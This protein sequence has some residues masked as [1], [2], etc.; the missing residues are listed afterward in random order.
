M[1]TKLSLRLSA[2]LRG[3]T[4][5]AAIIG[6][7]LFAGAASAFTPSSSTAGLPDGSS[8]AY[9]LRWDLT[10]YAS[11]IPYVI[12]TDN[13]GD[14]TKDIPAA[15]EF[16]ILHSAF[17]LWQ[18]VPGSRVKF[19]SVGS[20]AQIKIG[21]AD[22]VCSVG[23][24]EDPILCRA[25][26]LALNFQVVSSDPANPATLGRISESDIL[27]IDGPDVRWLSQGTNHYPT[28]P[29]VATQ[30]NLLE[31]AAREVGSFLGLGVSFVREGYEK[32]LQLVEN[33]VVLLDERG[34]KFRDVS[35]MYPFP[36]QDSPVRR[37]GL[38]AADDVAAL[39][40]KY[41][42]ADR[43]GVGA[44]SGK[45]TYRDST[46]DTAVPLAGAHVIAVEA[47]SFLPKVGAVSSWDGSYSVRGLAPGNYH[48][49]V[50]PAPTADL[51]ELLPGLEPSKM[52]FWP[53][54][55]DN[56]YLGQ[57]ESAAV[58][59]VT[60][61]QTVS[62]IDVELIKV[63]QD[64][65]TK[66]AHPSQRDSEG[67]RI[68]IKV[69]PDDNF[70][71]ATFLTDDNEDREI[72]VS[73][74]IQPAGDTDFYSIQADRDDIYEVEV[75]ARRTGSPLNPRINVYG[76][77]EAAIPFVTATNTPNYEGDARLI[78][79]AP[80]SA[81][82]FIEV[83]D[84]NGG[85]GA[86]HFYTLVIR[87][88]SRRIPITPLQGPT[89]VLGIPISDAD[90]HE[91][92]LTDPNIFG[93]VQITRLR[94]QFWDVDGD[95]GLDPDG[96][97]FLPPTREVGAGETAL[98]SG[99][100]LFNDDGTSVGIFD[101]DRTSV[102][103]AIQDN[104]LRMA[105]APTIQP[106]S[107]GFEVTFVPESPITIPAQFVQDEIPDVWVVV[108]PSLKLH[109]GDDFQVFIP[110]NGI[111]LRVN[112]SAGPQTI[113]LPAANDPPFFERDIFTGE[114]LKP[115]SF[116][117]LVGGQIDAQ[118]SDYPL[119]GLNLLGD[120]EEQYWISKIEVIFVGYS[121]H[122]MIQF[123][124]A[125][126]HPVTFVNPEFFRYPDPNRR[127]TWEMTDLLPLTNGEDQPGGV[128]VYL[129]NDTLGSAGDGVPN[130]GLDGDFL[131]ALDGT[132]HYEIVD[133]ATIPE[134]ILE[135]LIPRGLKD[136]I[137]FEDFIANKEDLGLFA[138]KAVLPLRP[139]P[140]LRFPSS[141]RTEDNT[142]GPDLFVSIRTS[143]TAE[144]LDVFFP[145]IEIGGIEVKNDLDT[146]LLRGPE[147]ASL[148]DGLTNQ[149][150][151]PRTN[152]NTTIIEVRPQPAIQLKDLISPGD[153][154]NR[155]NTIGTFVEGSAPLAAVGID[156]QDFGA[157]ALTT[158]N[159]D[160]F[161][162][163]SFQGDN[164]PDSI[165]EDILNTGVVL[166]S[167]RLIL[168]PVE[169]V[170]QIPVEYLINASRVT[171]QEDLDGL[172]DAVTVQDPDLIGFASRGIE[173]L[174]D[175][176]TPEGNFI[177]D[178]A[179]GLVDEE[180]F[181]GEDDDIDGITDES[182]Q[183][184]E[185]G[186]GLNGQLDPSDDVIAFFQP[187]DHLLLGFGFGQG[188][189]AAYETQ[190]TMLELPSGSLQ[191]DY[192]SLT[193][194]SS[195]TKFDFDLFLDPWSVFVDAVFVRVDH[196]VI[197]FDATTRPVTVDAG[198]VAD[199]IPNGFWVDYG[200]DLAALFEET[201]IDYSYFYKTQVPNTNAHP[202]F[203]NA[204]FF[205]ALR[206]GPSATSGD[207]FRVRIPADG[208]TYSTYRSTDLRA[209]DLRPGSFP[210][211]DFNTHQIR[212]GTTNVPP[213]LVFNSP[214]TTSEARAVLV[215]EP[216]VPGGPD[217]ERVEYEFEVRFTFN[218]PDN[219][220]AVD[221]YYDTNNFGV[222]GQ[223]IP[224]VDGQVTTNILD[225]DGDNQL[226]FLFRFPGE[227]LT[228]PNVEVFIYGIV[229][230]GINSPRAVYSNGSIRLPEEERE[231]FQ[232]EEFYLFD[233]LGQVFGTGGVNANI[234]D[235]RQPF[236]DIRD[237]ELMPNDRGA[238][239]LKA[240]GQVVLKG[241]A[242]PWRNF[243]RTSNVVDFGRGS[244]NF[245]M[246]LARD[247][248]PDF[249]RNGMYILDAY[250]GVTALGADSNVFPPASLNL[251]EGRRF[252][253]DMARDMELTPSGEGLLI[254]DG[255][256]ATHAIGDAPRVGS[257][258]YF[259]FDIARDLAM[260]PS[261][262]GYYLLDGYGAIFSLGDAVPIGDEPGQISR[263]NVPY[264][265]NGSDVYRA[266]EISPGN[267][268][269]LVM[270]RAGQVFPASDVLL[271]PQV[272]PPGVIPPPPGFRP[273]DRID[274][275]QRGP[276]ANV[277]VSELSGA[278]ID[279]ETVGFGFQFRG[280][281]VLQKFETA[282]CLQDLEQI[283]RLYAD[284]FLDDQGHNKAEVLELWKSF[285]DYYKV[286]GCRIPSGSLTVSEDPAVQNGL[287]LSGSMEI[288][289]L[290]PSV[291][292]VGPA[293]EPEELEDPG[294]D[295]EGA[296][297]LFTLGPI[298]FDQAVKFW[299]IAD[300]RGWKMNI[301]DDDH[302]EGQIDS[303]D[304]LLA[305]RDFFKR[306]RDRS[307]EG[308]GVVFLRK[309]VTGNSRNSEYIVQFIEEV[310]API[311]FPSG[312][313]EG[314]WLQPVV[315]FQM[316]LEDE[317]DT[318]P[319]SVFR[320][321]LNLKVTIT[322]STTL[323]GIITGG[324]TASFGMI[325]ARS[326]DELGDTAIGQI[327]SI[328]QVVQSPSGWRFFDPVGNVVDPGISNDFPS[329]LW[330]QEDVMSVPDPLSSAFIVDLIQAATDTADLSLQNF[331]QT[332][333]LVNNTLEVPPAIV[334]NLL[335]FY[336]FQKEVEEVA[337]G[338]VYLVTFRADENFGF[339]D[340]LYYATFQVIS[341]FPIEGDETPT[342]N[343][344]P[345]R[346][347]VIR[348]RFD[349]DTD[350][351]PYKPF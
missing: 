27:F 212:V 136:F 31:T 1:K 64:G 61:N 3:L 235:F 291:H 262:N 181:N 270:D 91:A 175:D 37:G 139:S 299:E 176:D 68:V 190:P 197:A 20:T 100:A 234:P 78:F 54:F 254:L 210:P 295:D 328:D 263:Q 211:S 19:Q 123:A 152:P 332:E 201:F 71:E 330:L 7:A 157:G 230:D 164:I 351:V 101:Y 144:S 94:I 158:I 345:N 220:A 196:P 82:Y 265:F 282:I 72:R 333:L 268:G 163:G 298:P 304:R 138:F 285:F 297:E 22:S 290:N 10:S 303:A 2:D 240:N 96:S 112:T 323:D 233:N 156:I 275:S 346:H 4:L 180:L 350:F 62:G 338:G 149:R 269:L 5:A 184:D 319:S 120:P 50:E 53:E 46:G 159:S 26:V 341:G 45:L 193:C 34:S 264:Q 6:T 195:E 49:W 292:V 13:L 238:L 77:G 229:D 80:E 293:D 109:H 107:N 261:G 84:A 239:F 348:W 169:N 247:V 74:R 306:N 30:V 86:A 256:G 192:P 224:F 187:N 47:G 343:N 223:P 318:L 214:A 246:D 315:L 166:D 329:H 241:D 340:R 305:R 226:T 24:V 213:T 127:R 73:D 111:E 15:D 141:D 63:I 308:S 189:G 249:Y 18:D 173:I 92:G 283:N 66:L 221:F 38:L 321:P 278:F 342:V 209:Q 135:D 145:Y 43:P 215:E 296:G 48:I 87:N 276:F 116:I 165:G 58:H 162:G 320:I 32:Q 178:D 103:Y 324:S 67:N 286:F 168:D 174:L 227:L 126:N 28:Q 172:F 287:I 219:T 217:F 309:E 51:Q 52:D 222:D 322:N 301:W 40:E 55:H 124:P 252:G 177:D 185:D 245:G 205:V 179:D 194:Q 113:R 140:V 121:L 312:H 118:S 182:D 327:D 202:R 260:T 228:N 89:A 218:D 39:T 160:G 11:G 272:I 33:R 75:I 16:P 317:E 83:T 310:E 115:T 88:L 21:Q 147:F 142:F 225:N 69:E 106:I 102:N 208:I 203:S 188:A 146:V 151:D 314:G 155:G 279:L 65:E 302:V 183:G 119:I 313:P 242:D 294:D 284:N 97:D 300:G 85:G 56:V 117:P 114:V 267:R 167:M 344:E 79:T 41:P 216:L 257:Q 281:T 137:A 273:G 110:S 25:G 277:V 132:Q 274:F 122:N 170:T 108:Q 349:P 29:T 244:V 153:P 288:F 186:I 76:P 250:G 171:G 105:T 133:L 266:I 232:T 70:D 251:S 289:T 23:F 57:K 248:E 35:I 198:T 339:R 129:D 280:N 200:D 307:R 9:E 81:F 259:G 316:F 148:V 154:N 150:I 98:E 336:T 90:L 331:I 326:D 258:P 271:G 325:V 17:K 255:Y 347:I 207:A 60:A 44:I 42:A 12:K 243:V 125:L 206:M 99:F 204:D 311:S 131:V 128:N 8:T 237:V 134:D 161:I 36:L 253:M 337:I 95:G 191:I 231:R 236:N 335:P 143:N 93:N 334:Q 59:V 199:I 104:S 130:F 14:G